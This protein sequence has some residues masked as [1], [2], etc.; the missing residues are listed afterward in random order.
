MMDKE[1]LKAKEQEVVSRGFQF[2]ALLILSLLLYSAI[3]D[4][5]TKLILCGSLILHVY[6]GKM[7]LKIFE[8]AL[9]YIRCG[10]DIMPK[11]SLYR[12]F[13]TLFIVSIAYLVMLLV[14]LMVFGFN[15]DLT[16]IVLYLFWLGLI[17]YTYILE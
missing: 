4:K 13:K 9:V 2:I 5:I 14:A 17:Y 7:K 12:L 11:S 3:F 10:N 8:E 1:Q 16:N 15:P 6:K